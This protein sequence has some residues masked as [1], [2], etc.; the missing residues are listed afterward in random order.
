VNAGYTRLSRVLSASLMVSDLKTI[1][2]EGRK[3]PDLALEL[4]AERIY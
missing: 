1:I 4:V 3:L 2:N